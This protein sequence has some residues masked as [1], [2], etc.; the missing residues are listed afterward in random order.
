VVDLLFG[1]PRPGLIGPT[2]ATVGKHKRKM[3]PW[4]VGLLIAIVVFVVALI[5]I[6]LLGFGDD[7]VVGSLGP[8]GG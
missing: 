6:D 5:A 1:E 7:P 8:V 3:P 4:L 2:V